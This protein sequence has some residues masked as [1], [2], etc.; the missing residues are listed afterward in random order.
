MASLCFLTSRFSRYCLAPEKEET[1][2]ESSKRFKRE[3][4]RSRSRAG[5]NLYYD[6]K[7][8]L[9]MGLLVICYRSSTICYH[10]SFA[11]KLTV[12][13]ND[14]IEKSKS[15]KWNASSESKRRGK[16]EGIACRFQLPPISLG[17]A[18]KIALQRK[19]RIFL[20]PYLPLTEFGISFSS[21]IAVAHD[22]DRYDFRLVKS[23]SIRSHN[24]AFTWFPVV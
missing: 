12:Q 7:E 2:A 23:A 5:M 16:K 21:L 19:R 10:V 14:G 20:S 4:Y 15:T 3:G 9:R 17:L 22:P 18:F 8:E 11:A 6:H 13:V 24:H 1:T